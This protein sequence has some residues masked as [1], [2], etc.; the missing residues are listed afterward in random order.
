MGGAFGVAIESLSRGHGRPRLS[1]SVVILIKS[2]EICRAHIEAHAMA[3]FEAVG[4]CPHVDLQSID[5]IRLERLGLGIS[6]TRA[7]SARLQLNGSAVGKYI[8]QSRAESVSGAPELT[9]RVSCSGPTT[10]RSRS[11]G[12]VVYVRTSAR[13]CTWGDIYA[14]GWTVEALL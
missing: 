8:A 10:S 3:A 6:I 14:A 4:R 7:Q 11:N 12:A 1:A 13:S 9:Y 5:S 2:R